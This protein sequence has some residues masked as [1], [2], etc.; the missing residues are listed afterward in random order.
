MRERERERER[1]GTNEL[2][3]LTRSHFLPL[4]GV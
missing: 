2:N 1:V 3:E 4:G